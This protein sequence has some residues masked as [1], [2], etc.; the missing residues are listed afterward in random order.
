MGY[1]EDTIVIYPIF[2]RTFKEVSDYDHAEMVLYMTD[3]L[4]DYLRMETSL[5]KLPDFDCLSDFEKAR[6]DGMF[7]AIRNVRKVFFPRY[8]QE[9]VDELI[10][11][12]K[13]DTDSENEEQVK[14]LKSSKL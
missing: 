8:F 4:Q 13:D 1:E 7:K 14:I 9:V 12:H 11:P 2:R 5:K 6:F 3:A 10:T